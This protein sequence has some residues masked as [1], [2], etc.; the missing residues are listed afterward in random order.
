MK[1]FL[2]V[3]CAFVCAN[4]SLLAGDT[5]AKNSETLKF[6]G[7]IQLQHAHDFTSEDSTETKDGFRM[8]RGRIQMDA[9]VNEWVSAKIQVE[10]RD[11]NPQLLDALAKV[12]VAEDV[13]LKLGQ[14]YVPVWREEL[15]SSGD[16]ILV[17]RSDAANMLINENVSGRQIG[18]G[19]VVGLTE[20]IDVELNVANGAGVGTRETPGRPVSGFVNDAKMLSGRVNG[21]FGDVEVGLSA[22]T[23][24]SGAED[25][26]NDITNSLIAPD[27]NVSLLDGALELEGGLGLGSAAFGD[28]EGESPADVSWM[29]WDLTGRLVGHFDSP[30]SFGGLD[31]YEFAFGLTS[32]DPNTDVDDNEVMII[33]GGPALLFGPKVRLQVN[34]EVELPALDAL[35]STF[36]LRTQA[37]FNI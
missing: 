22:V 14:F 25:L 23:N 17:E 19:V 26:G 5:E 2:C 8:R 4:V 20:E 27:F 10:I 1:N 34:A 13:T 24:T 30:C 6:S 16:L 7:R 32:L 29:V 33:R 28:G 35:E 3:V 21:A 12:K 18:V 15:R 36:T 31:G 11:N 37:T 9:T